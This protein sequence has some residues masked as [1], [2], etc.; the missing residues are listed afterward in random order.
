MGTIMSKQTKINPSTGIPVMPYKVEPIQDGVEVTKPY[1]CD[2]LIYSFRYALTRK[3][4]AP[5]LFCDWMVN[6]LSV[7]TDR[8]LKLMLQE[9]RQAKE[10][11]EI[12]PID[13]KEWKDFSH[14]I[15]TRRKVY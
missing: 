10:R 3:T 8:D 13:M 7:M 15:N 4:Y 12:D 14:A 1:L 5:S 9:I 11:G 2:I 6:N